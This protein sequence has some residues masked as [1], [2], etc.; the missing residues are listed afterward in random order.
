MKKYNDLAAAI[1]MAIAFV[2]IGAGSARAATYTVT[3]VNDSGAGSLREAI[4]AANGTA[5][6]DVIAFD[7]SVF[8]SP[9]TIVLGGGELRITAN[10]GLTINGT[11]A[12]RLTVS[13]FKFDQP[14]QRNRV[15]LID[16]GA[17]VVINGLSITNGGGR[18][19]FQS[20]DGGGIYNNRATLTLNAVAL[21]GNS[22]QRGGALFN[23]VGTV[24]IVNSTI[25]GN[26]GSTGGGIATFGERVFGDT[27]TI[28]ITNSTISGNASNSGGGIYYGSG[29]V[30]L[31]NSTVSGNVSQTAGSGGGGVYNNNN[32]GFNA[33]NSIIANNS[34]ASGSTTF[35]TGPDFRG[36]L[37]SQGY[38]LIENTDGATIS[39]DTTGNIYGVDPQLAA[40]ADNG[41]T[42]QTQ[43][44]M[45]GSPAVD[46][47]NPNNA[48]NPPTDQRGASS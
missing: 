4:A 39:G 13:S 20:L 25:S 9:R 22:A 16:E 32:T 24:N 44:L 30:N 12:D 47:A 35:R 26:S 21:R 23:N 1:L 41:G 11:G 17:N 19:S 18:S 14:E 34:L 5:A 33:R 31:V 6:N 27:T 42:T 48:A 45:P 46:A 28:N 40:L 38:N 2:I 43:A 36:R 8:S 3:N 10:G 15:F 37:E 7:D 29:E